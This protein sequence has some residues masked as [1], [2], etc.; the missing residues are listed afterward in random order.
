M[1]P[2]KITIFTRKKLGVC[3]KI[4]KYQLE[5]LILFI[6]ITYNFGKRLTGINFFDAQ[7]K[8]NLKRMKIEAKNRKELKN[9]IQSSRD[10]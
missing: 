8:W 9:E 6:E 3:I 7:S 5:V 2:C 4:T 1:E 10:I